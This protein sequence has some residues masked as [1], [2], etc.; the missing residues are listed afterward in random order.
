MAKKKSKDLLIGAHTSISGGAFN[1]LSEGESIGATTIQ[2][3]TANQR[4]WEVKALEEAAIEKW[5]TGVAETG[6]QKIMSHASYLINPGAPNPINLEKSRAAFSKELGRCITLGISYLNF[7]PGAAID[8]TEENC[9]KRIIET[10]LELE[11]QAAGGP[12]RLLLESTAGQGS[13]IGWRFEQLAAIIEGVKGRVPLGVCID[14]CHT[15]AAGYDMRTAEAWDR[16]VQE[17]DQVVG[18]EHLYAFHVNDSKNDIGTR[19]DRHANL[20]EGFIGM[21]CF[22]A[23]MTHPA[24]REL[25]KYLETPGGCESWIKEIKLLRKLADK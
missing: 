16:M 23:M 13:T 22:E 5:H 10:I 4:R 11:E 25:P 21:E 24:T 2:I 12:T 3:F 9:I 7:H 1:A 17:F 18:I 14:T 20:G 8:D 19:K 6:L 15:F